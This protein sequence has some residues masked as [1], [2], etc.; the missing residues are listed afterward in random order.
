[1]TQHKMMSEF[2][3]DYRF[4]NFF[5]KVDEFQSV[6]DEALAS[7]VDA[8]DAFAASDFDFITSFNPHRDAMD[9]IKFL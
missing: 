8:K 6:G 3:T 9:F 1:M 2:M 7:M 5:P 4:Y